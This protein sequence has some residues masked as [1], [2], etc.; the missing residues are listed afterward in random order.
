M[1]EAPRHLAPGEGPLRVDH[2]RDVVEDHDVTTSR[3]LRQLRSARVDR[4]AGNLELEVELPRLFALLAE[5]RADELREAVPLLAQD[6]ARPEVRDG[7]RELRVE[8]QHARGHV[9]EDI[10]EMRL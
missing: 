6:G 1:R 8:H 7:K 2:L 3:R 4:L 9:G 10:L 5:L